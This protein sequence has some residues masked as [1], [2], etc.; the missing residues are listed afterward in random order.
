MPGFLIG[1]CAPCDALIIAEL[2]DASPPCCPGCA[3]EPDALTGQGTI[4]NGAAWRAD[5]SKTKGRLFN[6]RDAYTPQQKRGGALARHERVI[7]RHG[8]RYF[9]KVTMCGTGLIV[10]H[11]E[12]PLTQHRGHGSDRKGSNKP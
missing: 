8:D 1:K 5:A 7:N 2:V 12:E 6:V 3:A 11:T 4:L 9:E 10:H